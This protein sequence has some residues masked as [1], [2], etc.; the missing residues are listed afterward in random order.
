MDNYLGGRVQGRRKQNTKTLKR[1]QERKDSQGGFCINGKI[2]NKL[3]NMQHCFASSSG[4][5]LVI[6]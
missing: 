2:E 4:Y 3:I 1:E 5:P 6:L